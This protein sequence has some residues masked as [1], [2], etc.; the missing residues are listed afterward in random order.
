MLTISVAGS[1]DNDD[2]EVTVMPDRSFPR[3]TVMTL[4]PPASERMALRKLSAVVTGSIL[5]SRMFRTNEFMSTS[6]SG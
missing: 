5:V 3:P 2:T 4:T 1:T 6:R